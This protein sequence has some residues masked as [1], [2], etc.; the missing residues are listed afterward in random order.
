MSRQ[1]RDYIKKLN[2]IKENDVTKKIRV[3]GTCPA[4]VHVVLN[5]SLELVHNFVSC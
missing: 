3:Y 1:T 5:Q 2:M 4:Y